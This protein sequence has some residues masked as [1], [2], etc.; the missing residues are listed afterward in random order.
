MQLRADAAAERLDVLLRDQY[1]Q[2]WR[3]HPEPHSATLSSAAEDRVWNDLRRSFGDVVWR[4]GLESLAPD[5]LAHVVAILLRPS[6]AAPVSDVAAATAELALGMVGDGTPVAQA[7]LDSVVAVVCSG[8]PV[9]AGGNQELAA[10]AAAT[11]TVASRIGAAMLAHQ[12]AAGAS[13]LMATVGPGVVGATDSFR[14]GPDATPVQDRYLASASIYIDWQQHGECRCLGPKAAQH[15]K[16]APRHHLRDWK[17]GQ[18]DSGGNRSDAPDLALWFR[19]WVVG[20]QEADDALKTGEPKALLPKA[21][22][23]GLLYRHFLPH[24]PTASLT[25]VIDEVLEERCVEAQCDGFA[26]RAYRY[27]SSDRVEPRLLGTRRCRVDTSHPLD[28]TRPPSS[29]A[30]EMIILSR[31]SPRASHRRYYGLGWDAAA[32]RW[33]FVSTRGATRWLPLPHGEAFRRLLT[34]G[35]AT[36]PA[37]AESAALRATPSPDSNIA[38][39]GPVGADSASLPIDESV[40]SRIQRAISDRSIPGR[41]LLESIVE[42]LRPTGLID[43]DPWCS[44][45]TET[46]TSDS[47]DQSLVRTSERDYCATQLE[48]I[49]MRAAADAADRS[50]TLEAQP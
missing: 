47:G 9:L 23:A 31:L 15:R 43:L 39:I 5:D 22:E 24:L 30:R 10:A 26:K 41:Q 29:R 27:T 19:T 4:A 42:L 1:G 16:R 40:Y 33:E 14:S 18:R 37:W 7:A 34:R 25:L 48:D 49:V 3:T 36:S 46:E 38:R 2:Q 35:A 12:L 45:C 20:Q 6:D 44:C 28:F 11:W 13:R 17:P 50:A 21:L 8:D 32:E